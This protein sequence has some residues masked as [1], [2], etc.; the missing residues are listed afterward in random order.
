MAQSGRNWDKTM[1]TNQLTYVLEEMRFSAEMPRAVLEQ[2][3][4]ESALRQVSAGAIVFREGSRSENLY[5]VR[6]GRIALEMNVPG[7]GAVRIL[8][9]GPGEMFGWSALLDQGTMT[10]SAV[11]V[12]P[13]EMIVSPADKLGELSEANRDFGF[14]LMRQMADSLSKRLV[15]TRLQLLDL[16]ADTAPAI[17]ASTLE[18]KA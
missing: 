15:A 16:F 10:A 8:T 18:G 3:A 17:P 1:D 14:H 12:E 7:R 13:T 6:R 4:A 2:L 5:L 11:A 9:V